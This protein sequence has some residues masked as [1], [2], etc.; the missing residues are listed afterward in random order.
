[1]EDK[2]ISQDINSL[3]PKAAG[4]SSFPAGMAL[5]PEGKGPQETVGEEEKL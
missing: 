2:S 4:P 3:L 1:M 5:G